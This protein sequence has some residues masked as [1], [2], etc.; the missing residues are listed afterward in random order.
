MYA[1]C[2]LCGG[3]VYGLP[4]KLLMEHLGMF[5]LILTFVLII[6]SSY[7]ILSSYEME[8]RNWEIKSNSPTKGQ[9]Q[10]NT[11]ETTQK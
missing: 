1:V 2:V 5:W 4:M 10:I 7:V 6:S 3:D 8:E 9:C 11:I